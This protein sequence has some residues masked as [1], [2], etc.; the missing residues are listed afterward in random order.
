M[1]QGTLQII[2]TVYYKQL[3][4]STK[5]K[6]KSI[7]LETMRNVNKEDAPSIWVSWKEVNKHT[8]DNSRDV[9]IVGKWSPDPM[10]VQY[11]N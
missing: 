5:Q 7:V 10:P 1:T 3:E 6:V 8:M 9:T 11:F 4:G 2:L